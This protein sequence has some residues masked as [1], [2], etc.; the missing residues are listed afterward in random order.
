MDEE[1]FD[2]ITYVPKK[3]ILFAGFSVYHVASTDIDFKCI[4]KYKIGNESSQEL[5]TEF[6][7][8]DVDNKY[9]DIWLDQ[10]VAVN[11]NKG[12][13]IMVRF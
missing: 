3:D 9:C 1:A 4:Y 7:Q 13:T 10:E 11:A 12:I 8:A 6:S 5:V 2:A